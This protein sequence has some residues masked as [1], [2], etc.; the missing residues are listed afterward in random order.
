MY[1]GINNFLNFIVCGRIEKPTESTWY[2]FW[3]SFKIHDLYNHK[4]TPSSSSGTT[5]ETR[6]ARKASWAEMGSPVSSMWAET[7]LG[8]HLTSGMP[9]VEQNI[10]T[11]ALGK[12]G[13]LYYVAFPPLLH[14]ESPTCEKVPVHHT[15]TIFPML[16]KNFSSLLLQSVQLLSPLDIMPLLNGKI[17]GC[18]VLVFHGMAAVSTK[19]PPV[20]SQRITKVTISDMEAYI[21]HTLIL[22]LKSHGS[23]NET[24]W[25][26]F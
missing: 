11:F 24:E 26:T 21:P 19:D 1:D 4:Y 7:F 14:I 3:Y 15:I 12:E 18:T 8:T 23:T 5:L 10:P 13:L 6:P 9:G 17:W 20:C 2:W 22:K 16:G 25:K